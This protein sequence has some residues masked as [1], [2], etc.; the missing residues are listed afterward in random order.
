MYNSWEPEHHVGDEL[1]A[2]WDRSKDDAAAADADAAVATTG[3]RRLG[4]RRA[5]TPAAAAVAPAAAAPAAAP[6]TAAAATGPGPG[7][8][9]AH[10]L[11]RE[12]RAAA[13]GAA[14]GAARAAAAPAP[15]PAPAVPLAAGAAG[16]GPSGARGG[17][18]PCKLCSL[19]HFAG[20]DVRK[21]NIGCDRCETWGL[22]CVSQDGQTQY[23]TRPE[24]AGTGELF[25]LRVV[26]CEQCK[27]N[28]RPC[29]RTEFC[30]SCAQ[31]G[32]DMCDRGAR[33][34]TFAPGSATGD[35][36]PLYFQALGW[37]G[38]LGVP[39]NPPRAEVP[40]P[41]YPME[42][43]VA[44]TWPKYYGCR[45]LD[46]DRDVYRF[47][48]RTHAPPGFQ[49]HDAPVV[50][51]RE[52]AD[53]LYVPP[54]PPPPP[55]APPAP[56]A[57]AVAPAPSPFVGPGFSPALPPPPPVAPPAPGFDYAL[58]DPALGGGLPPPAPM[59]PPA[60]APPAAALPPAGR[61]AGG[62][63]ADADGD[64]IMTD[65]E[66]E[67]YGR[68]PQGPSQPWTFDDDFLPHFTEDGLVDP[69]FDGPIVRRLPPRAYIT[70]GPYG[71]DDDDYPGEG[72]PYVGL[73]SAG[74][75]NFYNRST[76]RQTDAL[77]RLQANP[78]AHLDDPGLV[79]LPV[80]PD[81]L[82]LRRADVLARLGHDPAAARRAA[83]PV[84]AEYDIAP[85]QL[86]PL[87]SVRVRDPIGLPC[88]LDFGGG[89]SRD[90]EEERLRPHMRCREPRRP[91]PDPSACG[92][93]TDRWCEDAR[94]HH[95]QQQPS[96]DDGNNN[97]YWVCE[98]PCDIS[99]KRAILD[100]G[101][102]GLGHLQTALNLRMY[103]CATCTAGLA[104]KSAWQGSGFRV[105]FR[106]DDDGEDG[107]AAAVVS[108]TDAD[109][110]GAF[111]PDGSGG[112]GN[113][114][115]PLDRPLPA[116]TGC[117]CSAKLLYRTLCQHHRLSLADA[118]VRAAG[119]QRE[120]VLTV[121][122]VGNVC[123]RCLKKGGGLPPPPAGAG[124]VAQDL[125]TIEGMADPAAPLAMAWMQ[126]LRLDKR[127]AY[128]GLDHLAYMCLACQDRVV[129]PRDTVH[130]EIRWPPGLDPMDRVALRD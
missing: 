109:G 116:V 122:G 128:D 114:L 120:W 53:A 121:Y 36:Q 77:S 103:F 113:P 4:P 85:R 59:A 66:R 108:A 69:I 13:R 117:S 129:G 92:N 2:N 10:R 23:P 88:L 123:P 22:Q 61:A 73:L 124:A 104:K 5:A 39:K 57:P 67:A 54:P 98:D 105:W 91:W 6:T 44:K 42:L 127:G 96:P 12:E 79:D 11:S 101:N 47:R 65:A 18:A 21:T 46:P 8:A 24:Y 63:A 50:T 68:E 76:L 107:A 31:N 60:V 89:G 28:N 115:D 119:L 7:P 90:D 62:A 48:Q 70:P 87:T 38:Q 80:R 35:D 45:R 16:A 81:H 75:P 99:S 19:N 126:N 1:I 26:K 130:R 14:R 20:C 125:V 43:R 34:L 95:P 9:G 97:H 25:K 41:P 93:D 71:R 17:K 30:I 55:P 72:R 102:Q 82:L 15:A 78:D 74:Q 37:D 110:H 86:L 83:E 100:P 56:P 94:H 49:E 118:V 58:L 106:G 32:E 51:V 112:G 40:G 29:D 64:L 33:A 111:M 27:E 3:T 84:G 52:V